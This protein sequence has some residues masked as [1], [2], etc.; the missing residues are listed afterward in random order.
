MTVRGRCSSALRPYCHDGGSYY[1]IRNR[2][3]SAQLLSY[4]KGPR[5]YNTVDPAVEGG[6]PDYRAAP[7]YNS[8][9]ITTLIRAG[10]RANIEQGLSA[11]PN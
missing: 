7:P 11:G 9:L 5:C 10:G 8:P 4:T 3:S 2:C 1:G 6:P